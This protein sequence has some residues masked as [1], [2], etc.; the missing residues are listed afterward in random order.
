MV[1]K[2]PDKTSVKVFVKSNTKVNKKSGKKRKKPNPKI[3]ESYDDENRAEWNKKRG[4]FEEIADEL[5]KDHDFIV[6]SDN[7]LR[8]RFIKK[9]YPHQKEAKAIVIRAMELY[10]TRIKKF[11]I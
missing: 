5:S 1:K 11:S 9:N 10:R 6:L 2:K 4:Q 8:E 7:L 3:F